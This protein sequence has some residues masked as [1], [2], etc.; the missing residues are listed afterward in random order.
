MNDAILV[1][2]AV[3]GTF[4]HWLKKRMEGSVVGNPLDYLVHN[5]ATTISMV[6]GAVGACS[7]LIMS[8]QLSGLHWSAVAWLG[9]TTGYAIDSSVNRGP[10]P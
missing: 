3:V 6:M 1:G 5:P 2:A 7:A 4:V 8:G 9:L 10:K